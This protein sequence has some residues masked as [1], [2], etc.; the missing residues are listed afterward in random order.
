MNMKKQT[1]NEQISRIKNIMGVT[2]NESEDQGPSGEA[3]EVAKK[4]LAD[5]INREIDK[6][7]VFDD[8]SFNGGEI[9]ISFGHP[10]GESVTY[11]LDTDVSS[12]SSY[13][14]G[15]SHMPNGDPGYPDEYTNAEYDL[16]VQMME[17]DNGAGV[18][19]KGKDFTDIMNL[20][21]SNGETVGS[22]IDKSFSERI[23]EWESEYDSEP[24]YDDYRDED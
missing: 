9:M 4:V 7:S 21:L 24:D 16:H 22:Q 18:M 15:R 5:V 2:I 19:Y 3:I 10:D 1:L 8:E 20:E 12:H 13:S 6:Y 14:P 11:Y 17:I 23:G